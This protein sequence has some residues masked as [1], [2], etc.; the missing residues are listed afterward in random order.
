MLKNQGQ[1]DEQDRE[2]DSL[3]PLTGI[4]LLLAALVVAGANFIAVLDMTIANVSV[5][6]IAG[7]L[8]ATISQGTW[9]ITSYAVAEAIT[10]PL[11][12]WL[13]S[14]FGAVRVFI[15]SMIM[16]AVASLICGIAPTFGILVAGRVLQGLFGGPLMPLSQ[17]LL[18]QIFP[19]EK[20]AAA[21]GIWGVTTLVAPI[22][23]PI[24]GGYICNEYVWGWIFLINVP[25]AL[26]GAFIAIRLLR[27]YEL[28]T[29]RNPIDKVGLLLLVIWVGSLQIFLD[30]GKDLDW[31]SSN[32]VIALAI[33]AVIGFFAFLIWEFYEEHPAV[34]VRI[35]RHRGFT[36]GVITLS[37]G[38]A[39][40]FA[41]NVLTPLWLQ[42]FMGYSSFESGKTTA[43]AG[44]LAVLAAPMVAVL[45]SKKDPRRLVFIGLSWLGM[46]A[47]WRSV[48]TTDMDYAT[49]AFPL[50]VM[51]IGLPLFFVPLSGIA[52]G[53]V[54]QHEVASA[55]GLMSFIR[56]LSGA[57]GTSI[58]TTSWEDGAIDNHAQ[59]V[60]MVDT[61][62]SVSRLMESSGMMADAAQRSLDGLLQTQ[63]IMLSTNHLMLIIGIVYLIAASVIGFAP[64]P[65]RAIDPAAAGH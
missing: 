54:D 26:A 5:S 8:G 41:S 33:T 23:G 60:G 10:V 47:L 32:L 6:T 40:M 36:I 19:K 37:L 15:T 34:D 49:I 3:K 35:F 13:A 45:A 1:V 57:I 7:N 63:S 27:R 29:V 56:T 16:F 65:A 20:A 22:L 4:W 24:L 53:A 2:Q 62:Q 31:F 25:I 64:K 39:A 44:V 48:A 43:W 50:L 18:I 30:E 9:V 59:L 38:F 46:I 58:V 21:N 14:R 42:N 12:G 51:G 17:S 28:P 55:A 11:T 61:D 52:L